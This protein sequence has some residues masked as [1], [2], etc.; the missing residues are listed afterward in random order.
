MDNLLYLAILIVFSI[1][2]RIL[3]KK[4]KDREQENNAPDASLE[5]EIRRMAER[6]M[7][8]TEEPKQQP[9]VEYQ[10]AEP[11][12]QYKKLADEVK[13][14]P[15]D[16]YDDDVDYDEDLEPLEQIPSRPVVDYSQNDVEAL[17]KYNETLKNLKYGQTAPTNY[18]QKSIDSLKAGRELHT[19]MAHTE[20]KY[21][22]IET[23]EEAR[24]DLGDFD[25]RKA[26]I[27]AEILK[28]PEY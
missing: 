16:T 26:I 25:A 18:E 17:K 21:K 22:G 13:D 6:M 12:K 5:D 3:N 7:G 23:A 1:V 4:K 10:Q 15:Y 2:S 14:S 24:F 11:E 19:V 8:K 20:D 27:Y 9:T 28:R